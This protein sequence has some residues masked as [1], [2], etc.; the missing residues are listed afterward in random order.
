LKEVKQQFT[1]QDKTVQITDLTNEN[2]YLH[3]EV[4]RLTKRDIEK[5]AIIKKFTE[6]INAAKYILSR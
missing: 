6:Q 2:K 3:S 4:E 5:D 1:E